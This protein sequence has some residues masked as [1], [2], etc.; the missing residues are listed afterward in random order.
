MPV[1]FVSDAET[2]SPKEHEAP[3][4]S[5]DAHGLPA[6]LNQPFQAHHAVSRAE[7]ILVGQMCKQ[8]IDTGRL[9]WLEKHDL[10]VSVRCVDAYSIQRCIKQPVVLVG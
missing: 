5:D 9:Q 1:H 10:K 3:C 7:R 2:G 4:T 6:P 8:L